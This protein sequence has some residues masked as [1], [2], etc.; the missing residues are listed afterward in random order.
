MG[1]YTPEQLNDFSKEQI[2]SLFCTLQDQLDQTNQNLDRL[3]EQIRLAQQNRFGRRAEKIDQI[4]G[5]MSLFNEA[6]EYA[7]PDIPEPDADEVLIKVIA[8]KPKQKGKRQEDFKDLPQ[9]EIHHALTDEQLDQYFGKGCWRRMKQEE[10]T[11]VRCQPATFR[12]RN[13]RLMPLSERTVIIR[14]NFSAATVQ[15]IF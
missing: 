7:D 14:M 12:Q 6:E 11:R 8:K 2:I 4:A 15:R 10:F 13:I 5:Q 9:E 1:K 3:I